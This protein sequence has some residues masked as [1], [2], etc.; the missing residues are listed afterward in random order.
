M[1]IYD[2]IHNTVPVAPY[3]TAVSLAS[4]RVFS[5]PVL[6]LW[7]FGSGGVLKLESAA[8]WPCPRQPELPE[9]PGG[10]GNDGVLGSPRSEKSGGPLPFF[11]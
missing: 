2:N 9:Q 4:E 7:V 5:A 10:D 11:G 3:K 8:T 1:T 6:G